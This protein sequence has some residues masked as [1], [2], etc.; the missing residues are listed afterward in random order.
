MIMDEE[1][2]RRQMLQERMMQ[3]KME[4]EV[5]A[6]M[7]AMLDAKAKSRLDNLKTVKPEM[8]AQLEM[9]LA[10]LY[11]SGQVKSKISEEQIIEML[12][13]LGE[14]KEFRIVRR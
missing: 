5:K 3:E 10:Q 2:I 11:H 14:K 12:K 7:L 9:Y 13:K 6:T 8:A 1:D 4:K